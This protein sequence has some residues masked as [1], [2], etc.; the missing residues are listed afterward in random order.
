[1]SDFCAG[2]RK[3]A[4]LILS[5]ATPNASGQTMTLEQAVAEALLDASDQIEPEMSSAVDHGVTL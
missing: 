3:S 4:E 2:V 5:I 1:M